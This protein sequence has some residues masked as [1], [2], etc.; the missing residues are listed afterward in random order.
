[1]EKGRREIYVLREGKRM[2]DQQD[3]AKGSKEWRG[4]GMRD[5]RGGGEDGRRAEVDCELL[6]HK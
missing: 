6:A 5:E 2:R 1:M 4:G 3:R